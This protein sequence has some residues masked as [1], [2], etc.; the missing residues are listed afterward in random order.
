MR[1]HW[2][3]T[4]GALLPALGGCA[5][6]ASVVTAPV[7]FGED[8][9]VE[10][11]EVGDEAL[12]EAV[13]RAVPAMIRADRVQVD[14]LTGEVTFDTRRLGVSRELCEGEAHFDQP[15]AAGCSAT[16][17]DDDLVLTAGHCVDGWSCETQRFV[18]GWYY[19]SAGVLHAR[20]SADVFACAEVLVSEYTRANDYAIVRLDRPAPGPPLAVRM[21][22]AVLDEPVS[23][24]GYPFGLPMKVV[25]QGVVTGVLSRSRFYA[26]LDAHP[27][28]SGSGVLDA[29]LRV[30]GDLTNGPVEALRRDGTCNRLAVI[31]EDTWQTELISSVVP[32]IEALCAGGHE[33][34]R[35][36]GECGDGVCAPAE[37]CAADCGLPDAATMTDAAS[38]PDAGAPRTDADTASRDAASA[39]AAPAHDDGGIPTRLA[40]HCGCRVGTRPSMH[41]PLSRVV[42]VAFGATLARRRRAG[43]RRRSF[44]DEVC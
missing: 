23:L 13:V 33:S 32:A 5:P 10:V 42:A 31:G 17:I 20:D 9:R 7:I 11:Y 34:R 27:G 4:L 19:D 3:R 2:L 43:R 15:T 28:N 24:A 1:T 6:S 35:L 22:P 30:L 26:R 12:R 21:T 29:E 38:T 14:E 44:C 25:E 16:L 18:F 8:D 39:D 36:C 37:L 41:A 40:T